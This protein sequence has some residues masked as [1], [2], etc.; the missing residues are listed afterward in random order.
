LY[1]NTVVPF[2]EK[3][4]RDNYNEI[5]IVCEPFY[6]GTVNYLITKSFQNKSINLYNIGVPRK[7]LTNYGSKEEHD[8]N[9]LLD[10]LGIENQIK[11]ILEKK[12]VDV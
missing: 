12:H 5:I 10:S 11:F 8:K 1:Y 6:E 7:F 3:T 2:D 4:L 9:L